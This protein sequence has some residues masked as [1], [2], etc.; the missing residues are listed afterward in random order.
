MSKGESVYYVIK[1]A[2]PLCELILIAVA[3]VKTVICDVVQMPEAA[4]VTI[5]VEVYFQSGI[6]H[7][8]KLCFPR[9]QSCVS[10]AQDACLSLQPRSVGKWIIDIPSCVKWLCRSHRYLSVS[11]PADSDVNIMGGHAKLHPFLML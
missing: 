9:A 8:N 6:L 10:N 11:A 2:G 1:M 4:L 5:T 3:N 7:S